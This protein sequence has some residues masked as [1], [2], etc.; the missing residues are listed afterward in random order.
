MNGHLDANLA[1]LRKHCPAFFAW[2]KD[3]PSQPGAYNLLSSLSGLPDLEIEQPGGRRIILYNRENPFETVREELADQSFPNGGLSF[4][5]GLGLGYKALHILDAMDP[6]HAVYVVE[7][8]PDILRWALSLHDYSAEIRSGKLSF[9]VP[10]EE[11]LRRLIEEQNSAIL[12][13]RIRL[14]LEK[15]V[16][17]LD[18]RTARLHDICHSQFN[19]LLMNFNTVVKIGSTVIQNEVENLPKALLGWSPEGLM[20]GDF[21]NRPAIIVATGPS[22]QKNISLLRE[23]QGK[24]LIISVGQTLRVLLAYDVRP[25]I[26]CSIDFGEP[27]YLS[28]SDAIDK[29]NMPLLMHPQVYP[30]IPFEYQ[31]DLFVTLD[32]SNLLTPTG[33]NVSSPLGNAMTV[34]QTALN[35]A[36]AVGAD[37][38][39]FTGQDLAYGESSHIEGATYGKQVTVQGSRIIMKNEQVTKNQEVYWVPGYFGGRVPTNSGLLAFLEDIEETIRRNSGRRFIN[40][41]EGGAHIA[42]TERMAL[43][44]VLKTHCDQEFPVAD[45]LAAAR[46][47][48]GTDP[49]RLCRML[50]TSRKHVDRLLQRV[51]KLERTTGKMKS[52]LPEDGEKCSPQQRHQLGSLNGQALKSFSSLLESLE[53]D[54]LSRLATV[55]I[56]H[57]LIRME[58]PSSESG[59]ISASAE[60]TIRYCEELC[61]G[62]KDVCPSLLEKI[63]RVHPLLDEYA[64]VSADLK[65]SPP[66]RGAEAELRLRLGNCLQK[67]GHLGMAAEELERAA[68]SETSRAAALEA[69][70]SL[71]LNR[72]R[73]EL[74]GECLERLPDGHPKRDA[75]RDLLMKKQDRERGR[76][77][78]RARLCLDRGDFVGC[79]L[80]C[81]TLT[82][83]HGDSPDIQRM[84]DQSLAM[85][86]ERILEAQRQTQTERK[87]GALR[88]ERDRH[89]QI[90]RLRIKEKD[91]AAALALFRELSESDPRDEEAGLGC[92]QAY[93]KLQNWEGAEAEIRRLMQYQPERGM[94]FRELGNIL[95]HLGK[96]EEALKN[97]RKAVELDTG[98]NDLCLQIAAILSRA[99]KTADALP[100]YERHLKENPNDYR[101]LV[102]WGDGFLRLGIG[103]AAKLS[104]ET[105]LRIRPGYGPAVERLKRLQPTAS[106]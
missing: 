19:V 105:A 61:A 41:T 11:E 30:R 47:P 95:L 42:G 27:N 14:F 33:G 56:K 51:E 50:E 57:F 54:R 72:N 101:A 82:A 31:A 81:R 8:N 66:G 92:V 69:L 48:L 98:G 74:A 20:G 2:W 40:A 65:S 28:M 32:Q 88:D 17:L 21:R 75:F 24:A 6:S 67:M 4:L 100:F 104:Y 26:V 35:L 87:R 15:Y 99:G 12:N 90:A 78:E 22:L 25:D 39:V 79:L 93:E 44:D 34:A 96:S 37:P 3:C 71:H 49:R 1:A 5:F 63:D 46:R 83:L 64:T 97:F 62:L 52:L 16:R 58:E 45:Y 102:L 76:L 36:L 70:F 68:R 23:A 91:Y 77:L 73:F 55:R 103:A 18:A 85:R 80:A 60:R 13:G 43:R 106:S 7:R 84:L 94:L 59:E 9:V 89:L 10:E 38:I 29:A 86:E 53:E